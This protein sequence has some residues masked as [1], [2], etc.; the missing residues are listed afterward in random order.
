MRS[1][2]GLRRGKSVC[3]IKV[4]IREVEAPTAPS[5]PA[6]LREMEAYSA[7]S[8]PV[9]SL[10]RGGLHS[11]AIAGFWFRRVEALK[12]LLCRLGTRTSLGSLVPVVSFR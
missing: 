7:R 1:R 12:D 9:V 3:Q 4:R 6:F 10:G 8:L 5:P 11:S 2:G